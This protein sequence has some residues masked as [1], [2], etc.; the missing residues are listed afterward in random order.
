MKKAIAILLCA[1]MMMAMLTACGSSGTT[2]TVQQSQA[3]ENQPANNAVE[4]STQQDVT[5]HLFHQKQE[6]QS[7]FAQ[8]IDAFHAEYPY[9]NVEQE[10]VTNDPAAI[11]K[12]RI[13]TGEVPDIFQGAND[14]MD[15]AQGG[16]IMELTGEAFLN[17]ITDEAR[18][19]SSFT[20]SEGH[21]WAMPVDGSCEG[22]FYNKDIFAQYGLSVPTT[23]SEFKTLIET[24]EK[25]GVTPFAMGFKDAWTIKPVSLV[26]A[27]SAIYGQDIA[28]DSKKDSGEA[29]FASTEGWSTTFELTKMVYEHGNTRTAFDT[30]YNGACA[31]MAN[32]EAAMMIN[33]LWALEPI[34]QINPDVNL[35][36][37]AMPAT[38]NPADTKLFQFPDFGLSISAS[39]A[40]PEECKLFLEFLTRPEIAELWC[41]TS[42]LF[43]AVK[44]VSVDFDPMADDVNAYIDAGMVCTQVDR[45]WPTAFGSEYESALSNYILDLVSLQDVMDS[46]DTAWAAARAASQS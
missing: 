39:T 30:D 43:S 32:G 23:L 19:A 36:M 5:I 24:L 31:M 41:S 18:A 25:N 45:G 46:L 44:G 3:S 34:K 22:I 40:H 27:S 8:I 26:A 17:N 4:P 29:S 9:I 2:E 28:W 6:A 38:E 1:V 10:I 7:A 12:A 11:L 20:D 15:I 13:A 14:T 37:M 21:T 42:K 33:G 35:G 16:Y